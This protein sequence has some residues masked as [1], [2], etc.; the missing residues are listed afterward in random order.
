MLSSPGAHLIKEARFS[1]VAL[2]EYPDDV[3]IASGAA[4]FA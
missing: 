2:N 3:R 4:H 1:G